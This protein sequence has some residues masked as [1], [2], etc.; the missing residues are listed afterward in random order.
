MDDYGGK[1]TLNLCGHGGWPPFCTWLVN[2]AGF[3]GAPKKWHFPGGLIYKINHMNA[4]DD[5]LK[6]LI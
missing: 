2:G 4:S 5:F 6:K 1:P 3:S